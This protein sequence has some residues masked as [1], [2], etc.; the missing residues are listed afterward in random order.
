MIIFIFKV[1]NILGPRSFDLLSSNVLEA[2]F[3][4]L[5]SKQFPDFSFKGRV[6][7]LSVETCAVL[8]VVFPITQRVLA[9]SK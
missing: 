6:G 5:F 3:C 2:A 8:E 7:Q 1:L 9:F 4:E